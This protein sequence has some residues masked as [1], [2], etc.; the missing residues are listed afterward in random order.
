MKRLL[1]LSLVFLSFGCSKD[2]KPLTKTELLSR[3]WRQ[4]D[5]LASLGG[6]AQSSV[7]N[8]VLTPCQQDNLWKFNSNGT[9][10]VL[11]GA[12]KCPNSTSDVVSTGTW[13]F[14]EN[15]TKL[16]FTDATNGTQTFTISEL[17]AASMKLSGTATYQGTPVSALVIFTAN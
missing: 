11:E 14:L 5:I 13:A 1:I 15:E 7:F 12:T 10:T 16:T 17:T 9:Y 4:T 2:N 6:G 3:T 8:T